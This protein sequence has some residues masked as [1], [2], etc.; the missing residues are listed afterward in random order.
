MFADFRTNQV[1]FIP[2]ISADHEFKKFPVPHWRTEMIRDGTCPAWP[3]D[4]G[5][6]QDAQREGAIRSGAAVSLNSAKEN[7][8]MVLGTWNTSLNVEPLLFMGHET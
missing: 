1:R 6:H 2:D 8:A 4:I 3:A 7:T 5:E